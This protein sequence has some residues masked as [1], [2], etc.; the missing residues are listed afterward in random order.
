LAIGGV[1]DT[2]LRAASSD[3]GVENVSAIVT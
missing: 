2:A 3:T 1:L